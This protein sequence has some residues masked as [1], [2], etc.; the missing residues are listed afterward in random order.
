MMILGGLRIKEG[1]GDPKERC[2]DPSVLGVRSCECRCRR[3][4]LKAAAGRVSNP[5]VPEVAA[6]LHQPADQSQNHQKT[7]L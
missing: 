6:M 4:S 5:V 2:E 1:S 7:L 3:V